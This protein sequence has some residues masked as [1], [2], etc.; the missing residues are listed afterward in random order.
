VLVDFAVI[1][2]KSKAKVND[3]NRPFFRSS[4]HYATFLQVPNG[5]ELRSDTDGSTCY[6]NVFT[7]VRWFSATDADGRAYFYEENGNE[8]SW[9]LPDVGQSIQDSHSSPP[10]DQSS[11]QTPSSSSRVKRPLTGSTR[12]LADNYMSSVSADEVDDGSQSPEAT[13]TKTALLERKKSQQ[14]Q[15]QLPVSTPSFQIGGVNIVVIRQGPLHR[16]RLLENGRRHRKNW[17]PAHVVLTDTFLLFFRDAKA[18]AA[19]QSGGAGRPETTVDLKG[20]CVEWSM[21]KSKRANVFE[22]SSVLLGTE[23]L[24][25]DDSLQTAA[26]W[27]QEIREVIEALGQG[28]VL[29]GSP[30]VGEVS[31]S[32]TYALNYAERLLRG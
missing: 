26:E 3:V 4:F 30:E 1:M 31:H 32:S 25:Q 12:R 11:S 27:F 15:R 19:M 21:D 18:F 14:H 10:N 28:R 9:R 17:A 8:S 2:S 29:A 24:L 22:L 6:V 7:G 13:V 23:I 5:Y 20:A 16:A